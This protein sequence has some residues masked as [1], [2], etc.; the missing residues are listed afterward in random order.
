ML[1]D[2]QLHSM[3]SLHLALSYS[4]SKLFTFTSLLPPARNFTVALSIFG[5]NPQKKTHK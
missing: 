4:L 2:N 1:R 5:A 3:K